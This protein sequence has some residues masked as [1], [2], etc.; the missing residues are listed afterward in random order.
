MFSVFQGPESKILNALDRV[1]Y[2][3]YGYCMQ[4]YCHNTERDIMRERPEWGTKW[5]FYS[6]RWE[7]TEAA[8]DLYECIWKYYFLTHIA[9]LSTLETIVGTPIHMI[10]P[11]GIEME[12]AVDWYPPGNEQYRKNFIEKIRTLAYQTTINETRGDKP[13]YGDKPMSSL[14]DGDDAVPPSTRDDWF[15]HTKQRWNRKLVNH[16]E[17]LVSTNRM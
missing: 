7:E 4:Y 9:N 6:P 13:W 11:K 2:R 10:D 5:P 12:F 15:V 3:K 14:R 16:L 17:H 1:H 8:W